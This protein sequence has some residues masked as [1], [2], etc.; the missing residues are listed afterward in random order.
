MGEPQFRRTGELGNRLLRNPAQRFGYAE[1][2]A[3]TAAHQAL[4]KN[5]VRPSHVL[6]KVAGIATKVLPTLGKLK[7]GTTSAG[8]AVAD[9]AL[10]AT[11]KYFHLGSF[12]KPRKVE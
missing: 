1:K 7:T 8:F 9:A 3:V 11:D 2:R 6:S 5:S 4:K 10:N 12:T